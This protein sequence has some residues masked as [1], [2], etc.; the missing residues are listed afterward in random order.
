MLGCRAV[1]GVIDDQRPFVYKPMLKLI[2]SLE[3]GDHLYFCHVH[4]AP[5]VKR[6]GC[7]RAIQS[8]VCGQLSAVAP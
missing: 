8:Q 5:H 2:H 4:E 3:Q 6:S 7:Y 1:S